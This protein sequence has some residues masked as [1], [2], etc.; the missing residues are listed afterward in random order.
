MKISIGNKFPVDFFEDQSSP[1]NRG[2]IKR[3]SSVGILREKLVS[4]ESAKNL[5]SIN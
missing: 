5:F 2:S 1:N 3:Y 4:S